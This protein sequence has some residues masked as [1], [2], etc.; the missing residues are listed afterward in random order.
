[1]S[2]LIKRVRTYA[3]R[4]LNYPS[5]VAH[6]SCNVARDG[7]VSREGDVGWGSDR[8][9]ND[10]SITNRLHYVVLYVQKGMYKKLWYLALPHLDIPKKHIANAPRAMMWVK[11]TIKNASLQILINF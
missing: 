4:G 7:Y 6:H 1:M 5:V 10:Q 8:P 11:T 3:P 2:L 9:V